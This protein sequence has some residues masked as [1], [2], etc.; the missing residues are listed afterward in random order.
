MNIKLVF[1]VVFLFTSSGSVSATED[2]TLEV[3]TLGDGQ[4][5]PEATILD[6]AWLAG[7]WSGS[8]LGGLSEE[9][10]APAVDGQM[11][12]MF[13]QTNSKGEIIFYEFYLFTE[14][15][16]SIV[17]RIK[18]FSSELKGWEEK[19]DY[20]E[21]PLVAI[22][23]NAVYFSG[24]TYALSDEDTLLSAVRV[25]GQGIINFQFT[26]QKLNSEN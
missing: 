3:R 1:I 11:M 24:L 23:K 25:D 15:E 9:V 20:V 14:V 4:Q 10:I 17:L 12:G 2:Q 13:R 26:R 22:E 7:R 16:D 18:H 19:D 8:G 5:S 21:F 6:I